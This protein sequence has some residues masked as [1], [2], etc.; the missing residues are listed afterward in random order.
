MC[1][2]LP[3]ADTKEVYPTEYVI[4]SQHHAEKS[5][6]NI[7]QSNQKIIFPTVWKSSFYVANQKLDHSRVGRISS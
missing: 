6:N 2:P 1:A 3:D 5:N 4:T 7:L